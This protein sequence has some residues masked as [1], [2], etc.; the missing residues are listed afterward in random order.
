MGE[1]GTAAA[2]IRDV[3][4]R[5]LKS[6]KAIAAFF[7]KDERTVK[8][9]EAKR[10][11]PVHRLPGETH[12]SV[13]AYPAELDIW[14]RKSKGPAA[15]Q[16]PAQP[17]AR[18]GRDRRSAAVWLAAIAAVAAVAGIGL[19]VQASAPDSA[20]RMIGTANVQAR[21]LYLSGA[22]QLALRTGDG[23]DRARQHFGEAIALDPKFAEAYAGLAKTYNLI[24]QYTSYPADDAYSLATSWAQRALELNPDLAE[25]HGALAFALFYGKRDFTKARLAFETALNLDPNSAELNHWFALF[26]MHFAEF[27]QAI[28]RIERAQTLD[29]QSRAIKAN[30][31]LILYHAGRPSDAERQ[32]QYLVEGAPGYVAPY[33]Y[34]ADL[35]FEQAR[36]R[37]YLDSAD[38][39]ARIAKDAS[40]QDVLR[41]ARA[42]FER[43]GRDGLLSAAFE[44]TRLNLSKGERCA[45]KLARIAAQ[46]G[47]K[48][49]SLQYLDAALAAGERD[50]LAINIDHAFD[51]MRQDARF[52]ERVRSVG[53]PATR[54]V[55]A[56]S[57]GEALRASP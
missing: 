34:L 42:G 26:A 15:E 56:R 27:D 30:K 13:F 55:V 21:D 14:L 20:P 25:A 45:Y 49:L 1:N 39:A 43:G 46:R 48:E 40:M 50:V 35:Y 32:L 2:N 8:R 23:F 53:F 52:T 54:Q 29:P 33:Y 19:H 9:W 7:G 24:S 41:A 22:Y 18:A 38:K 17:P 28:E 31:G 4:G 44:Q 16:A 37:D 5:P 3:N 51:D 57:A 11:L 36:F 12:G 47:D 6:W 10:G